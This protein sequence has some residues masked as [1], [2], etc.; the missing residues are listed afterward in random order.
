MLILKILLWI[1][2]IIAVIVLL[3]LFAPLDLEFTATP[4]KNDFALRL[5]RINLARKRKPKKAKKQAAKP[6]AAKKQKAKKSIKEKKEKLQEGLEWA[7][8]LLNR[9][10]WLVSN[11]RVRNFNVKYISGGEDAA[12]AAI[13]YGAACALIYPIASVIDAK[14]HVAPNA[15]KLNISCDYDIKESDY[16]F[17]VFLRLRGYHAVAAVLFIAYHKYVKNK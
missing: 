5:Y 1:I 7:R 11:I 3:C 12:K 15:L 16:L 17:E 6:K 8:L 14:M 9:L 4:K 2:A 10:G 13:E